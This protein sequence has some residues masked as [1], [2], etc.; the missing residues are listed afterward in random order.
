MLNIVNEANIDY[1]MHKLDKNGISYKRYGYFFKT[2]LMLVIFKVT[3]WKFMMDKINVYTY[4]IKS[5]VNFVLK[6]CKTY[7]IYKIL[8]QMDVCK[9]ICK[10]IIYCLL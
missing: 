5:T 1:F 4:D 7:E 9:D 2:D 10:D 8:L 6:Y 3:K